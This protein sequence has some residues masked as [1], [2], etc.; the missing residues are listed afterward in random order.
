MNEKRRKGEKEWATSFL[1]TK[2]FDTWTGACLASREIPL[3]SG[4]SRIRGSLEEGHGGHLHAHIAVSYSRS[5]RKKRLISLL[6]KWDIKPIT[7][8]TEWRAFQYPGD[9]EKEESKGCRIFCVWGDE[10]PQEPQN[11]KGTETEKRLLMMKEKIDGGASLQEMYHEDF[12]LMMRYGRELRGYKRMVEFWGGK[13][14]DR[15]MKEDAHHASE[16]SYEQEQHNEII[17]AIERAFELEKAR[18]ENWNFS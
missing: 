2:N 16:I 11:F 13:E 7:P 6:P 12:F 9:P 18:E 15:I 10:P 5:Q 3:L 1:L 4:I 14:V 17:K 8:G